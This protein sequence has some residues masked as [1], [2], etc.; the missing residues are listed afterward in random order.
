MPRFSLVKIG[1]ILASA[2]TALGATRMRDFVVS[3]FPRVDRLITLGITHFAC[4]EKRKALSNMDS[5]VGL[6]EGDGDFVALLNPI[7]QS[8]TKLFQAL[9]FRFVD[10]LVFDVFWFGHAPV[11]A[12]NPIIRDL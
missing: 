10:P 6:I 2:F 11:I 3:P 1:K 12:H 4:S 9:R 7:P 5:G 8:S